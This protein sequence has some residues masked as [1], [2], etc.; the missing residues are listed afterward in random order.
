[1]SDMCAFCGPSHPP[2]QPDHCSLFPI[3]HFSPLSTS[4]PCGPA[5]SQRRE[6][7]IEVL[8]RNCLGEAEAGSKGEQLRSDVIQLCAEEFSINIMINSLIIRSLRR[9]NS[10]PRG[11]GGNPIAWS[12]LIRLEKHL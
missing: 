9:Q 3:V 11:S 10:S 6:K 4:F 7:V 2:R 1:M 5:G 12:F 8:K